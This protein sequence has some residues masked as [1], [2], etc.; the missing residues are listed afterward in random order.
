MLWQVSDRGWLQKG[1][2][3]FELCFLLNCGGSV[4]SAV[5]RVP[6]WCLHDP[7]GQSLVALPILSCNVSGLL[8]TEEWGTFFIKCEPVYVG[9][10]SQWGLILSPLLSAWTFHLLELIPLGPLSYSLAKGEPGASPGRGTLCIMRLPDR[11][12]CQHSR[13]LRQRPS[14]KAGGLGQPLNGTPASVQ[15]LRVNLSYS[16]MTR[17]IPLPVIPYLPFKELM[18]RSPPQHLFLLNLPIFT[19]M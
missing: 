9:E 10:G 4:S 3:F 13:G 15:T 2:P 16:R 8:L 18:T 11:S 5:K 7:L 19:R 14:E 12:G 1:A 6:P 17:G